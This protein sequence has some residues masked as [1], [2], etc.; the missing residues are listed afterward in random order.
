MLIFAC[1]ELNHVKFVYQT[2]GLSHR[3]VDLP[4]VMI[5]CRLVNQ[6]H[7]ANS[8]AFSVQITAAAIHTAQRIPSALLTAQIT[9]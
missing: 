2:E 6:R 4:T 5:S 1:E 8:L 9:F 3:A 7:A